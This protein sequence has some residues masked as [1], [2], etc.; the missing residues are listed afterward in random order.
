MTD[1]RVLLIDDDRGELKALTRYLRTEAKFEVASFTNGHEAVEHLRTE[2]QDYTA[3]LLDYVLKAEEMSGRQVFQEIRERHPQLP[4]IVF[5]GLDPE[6]GVQA[7]SQGAYRYLR[8]PL[9][10]VELVNIL[11]SLAEQEAIFRRMAQDVRQMLRSDMCLVWRLDKRQQIL[12]VVAWDGNKD[13]TPE[14]RQNAF[15]ELDNPKTQE[16]LAG[17]RPLLLE[18]VQNPRLAPHYL[19]REYA[20]EHGWVSLISIPLVHDERTVGLIDSYTYQPLQLD[21]DDWLRWSG[22]IL[23]A[24]ARYAVEAY[25]SAELGRQMQVLGG[26]NRVLTGTYEEQA[27][28]R[29]ILSRGL[30][31]VGAEAGWLYLMNITTRKL[32]L[33]DYIGLPVKSVASVREI[34]EGITGWVIQE[35]Q[36]QNIADVTS[37]P[38]HLATAGFE[39]RSELAVP[40]RR[41]EQ[42]IGAIVAKS[43]HANA[44]T[45]DDANLLASLASQAAVVIGRTDLVNHLEELSKLTLTGDYR[46]VAKYA[47]R[48]VR[49]L[50]GAEVILWMM[51]D[52]PHELGRFL[53]PVATAGEFDQ[54]YVQKAVVP[55]EPNN[56]ITQ[57]ALRKGDAIIRR[58]ILADSETPQFHNIAEAQ[59]KGWHSLM[60]VPL[61]ARG[62]ESLGSLSL[63]S[64][65]IAKFGEPEKGLL[66]VLANQVVVAFESV[67]S[68]ERRRLQV[69]ALQRLVGIIGEKGDPLPAILQEAIGLFRAGQG[70]ISLVDHKKQQYIS[71]AVWDAGHLLSGDEIP[72]THKAGS[73]GRGMVGYVA[74][75][76]Q[77]CRIGDV[78]TMDFYEKWYES[79]LSELAVPIKDAFDQTIGV[80]NLESPIRDA[81][82]KEDEELCQDFASVAASAFERDRV[83][84]TIQ[85]L[86]DQLCGRSLE[87]V[88]DRTLDGI[89]TILGAD[90]S[91]CISLLDEWT[92]DFW[93]YRA[94]GP[95]KDYLLTVPPRSAGT[96]YHVL[97]TRKPVYLDDAYQPPSDGPA[98]RK[99][100]IEQGVRSFAALPLEH[101]DR[102]VGLLFVNIQKQVVFTE[103]IK[104]VLGIFASQAAIAI[105]NS[106]VLDE[107]LKRAERLE[108]LQKVTATISA[109]P[110]DLQAVLFSVVRGVSQ[111]FKGATCAVRLYNPETRRFGQRVSAD[112]QPER[113]DYPPRPDG[114]SW[115]VIN[116]KAPLFIDDVSRPQSP[117]QPTIRK[118]FGDLGVQALAHLPLLGEAES[119]KGILYIDLFTPHRFS[120][121]DKRTLDLFASQAAIAIENAKLYGQLS[122]TN[123]QLKIAIERQN[124]VSELGRQLTASIRLSKTEI[125]RLLHQQA[126]RVMDTNNMYIALYDESTDTVRFPLA[127]LDGRQV[128]TATEEGWQP[129]S[130][131]QGR[132]EWIIRHREFLLDETRAQ[133]EA[134]Y[135]APG[136][137]EYIG[138]PFA[139]WVGVPMIVGDQVLGVIATYH[140]SREYV[141]DRDDVQVLSMMA[142]YAAV[143][144]DNARLVQ[145][146]DG[147]VMELDKLRALSEELSTGVWLGGE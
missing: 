41:E 141:Y 57:A 38:R 62:D 30:E 24:F 49:E 65:E 20:K 25:R 86:H 123:Q 131:G 111:I 106:R 140:A 91:S 129:R 80:L 19:H 147:R 33:V 3:V 95:L 97:T 60:V 144:L 126:S 116:T 135:K 134:W 103:E 34:G 32:V 29:Q 114:T 138:Q 142:G 133:S 42:T 44:F 56:S 21:S 78:T 23:P 9:D 121:D 5:T 79:T 112:P 74:R 115:H 108:L 10:R 26:V 124:A 130:G 88:L 117:E 76:G 146:L 105:E 59:R 45:D 22:V 93:N 7:P 27:I 51:S 8:K 122:D 48:A 47:A 16:H 83:F 52:Q 92:D 28:V 87:D 96:G 72:L 132:T 6:S 63:Y 90:T 1:I 99:E 67:R 73:L 13:P 137:K 120:E 139:S 36:T 31:L 71:A 14:Y 39:T 2:R 15:L 113:W 70:S 43:K 18:D 68:Q 110:T 94:A 101:Q 37:D 143:A 75:T 81:F 104:R 109:H 55:L 98:I 11:R 84:D 12:K 54:A 17:G 128:D 50:T 61:L 102:V 64:K 125:I 136:R 77:P 118:E 107:L 46:E 69:K 89:N 127:Y 4:V 53:R 82:S 100:S 66:Q 35:G 119:V 145:E 40:L 58:D 85:V